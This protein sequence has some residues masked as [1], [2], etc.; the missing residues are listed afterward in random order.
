MLWGFQ[1][2]KKPTVFQC[3]FEEEGQ[4]FKFDVLVKPVKQLEF[5]DF[6]KDAKQKQMILQISNSKVKN[7]LKHHMNYA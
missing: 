2:L 6:M 5:W 7:T 3:Q 4:Q 1:N